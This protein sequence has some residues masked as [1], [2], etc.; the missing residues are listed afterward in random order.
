MSEISSSSFNRIFIPQ[1]FIRI[2]SQRMTHTIYEACLGNH[3]VSDSNDRFSQ[4]YK[5]PFSAGST[6]PHHHKPR[7]IVI[8]HAFCTRA[9]SY[10][11]RQTT[12][13]HSRR[14]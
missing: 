5:Q 11:H 8:N 12:V 13:A 4:R 2:T 1:L 14:I 10:N 6:N 9:T 3:D 7:N